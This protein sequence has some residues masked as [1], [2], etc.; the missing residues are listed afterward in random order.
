MGDA[1]TALGVAQTCLTEFIEVAGGKQP[2]RARGLLR[3]QALAQSDVGHAEAHIRAS[4]ALLF[5]TVDESWDVATTT[6]AISL[7]QRASIRLATTHA[8]RSAAKAVDMLY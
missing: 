3:D 2:Y 6:G 8:I 1:A 5:Q 7:E 4:R